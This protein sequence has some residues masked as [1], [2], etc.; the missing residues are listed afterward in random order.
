M[1]KFLIHRP[2]AVTMTFIAILVLGLIASLR[3]PV[4]LMPS[5]DI[6]RI[7]VQVSGNG[8]SAR[9]LENTVVRSLR[10]Q[11]LQVSHLSEL[12]SETRDGTALIYL[13]FDYG[14]DI[15]FAF[16]E[17]NEKIDRAMGS[18]P[19][20]LSRPKVIKAS[21]TDIPVFY[22]NIS[23][24][25]DSANFAETGKFNSISSQ[26]T[27]LSSFAANV[28]GKRIEQLPEVAMVDLSGRVFP[29]LLIIPD[30]QKMEALGI[31]LSTLE[32]AIRKND[33]RLGNLLIHNGQYQY[34][35]RFTSTLKT[36]R[37]IENI[38]LKV[39]GRLM[40]MKELVAVKDQ[41][42]KRKGLVTSGGTLAIT[43]AIIKQSDAR[44]F[45]LKKELYSLVGNFR[46][47]YPDLVF[48]INRDQTRLLDYSLSN[49]EQSLLYGAIL[50]FAIMFF[51]LKDYKSPFLVGITIPVS[52]VISLLF[53]YLIGLSI[54][55]ISLSGLIL[56]MGMMIDNSIIVIDNITQYRERGSRLD[57]SCVTATNEVIRPMLSS[58]LTTCAIFIPLIFLSGMGGA[59]FYDQAMAVTIGMFISLVVSITLLPVYYRLMYLKN[60]DMESGKLFKRQKWMD[61]GELYEKGFRYVMRHQPVIWGIVILLLI[62]GGIFF[63]DMHKSKLPPITRDEV[64]VHI[65]WNEPVNLEENNRRVQK[66]VHSLGK[67]IRQ[68]TCLVGEQQFLLDYSGSESASEAMIYIKAK[69]QAALLKIE[70]NTGSF[71]QKQ[72]PKAAHQFREAENVFTLLFSGE[73]PPLVIRLRAT[74]DF[75]PETN[76]FLQQTLEYL[77]DAFPGQ[78]IPAI[79]WKNQLV[80]KTDPVKLLTYD[81]SYD[82]V[83][84][85]LKSAFSSNRILLITQNRSYVP[86]VLGAEP[87]LINSI[88]AKTTV[89]NKDGDLIP[90]R[91]LLT[92]SNAWDLKTI[93]AGE[94]GVYYPVFF[95]IRPGEVAQVQ[96]KVQEVLRK[97]GHFEA[98][99]TGSIFSNRKMM[100]Q[101]AVILSISLLLLY[102]ILAAQFESL[103][104]P[105]IL[106]AEI[107]VDFAGVLLM[108]AIFKEGINL[109]SMIGIIVMGGIVINDSIL[110]IDTINQLRARGYSLLHAIAEGGKRRLKP[111]LMTSLTTILALIPFLFSKG[112]GADLQRPLALA[113]I[114]GLGLGTFVSLYFVPLLYYLMERRKEMPKI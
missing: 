45:D 79:P 13:D 34:N 3:I 87:T 68:N 95:N 110:K 113:V 59:L 80:L 46:E 71:L 74:G 112:L 88:L 69:S 100:R 75:G 42:Q 57:E 65:D 23:L 107:P 61:Y 11:L 29:E 31:S 27:A 62:T 4:S 32:E 102:F 35:I 108:L 48:H 12:N 39:E 109:M 55:I 5:I 30:K 19:R 97:D 111:I 36:K 99:F 25:T 63:Y 18:L 14:A 40:Q 56:G 82:V 77:R 105:F 20:D 70:D 89:P 37:D 33:I 41:V 81:V 52:L 76:R 93:L 98:D 72:Y 8:L 15:D 53:F 10:N 83:Y 66:M 78:N 96:N 28:I 67:D 50:A 92:Q 106:L 24:K 9:E 64:M 58:V 114:G 17:V 2:I 49:L 84:R 26:F 47:D 104:L 51:F 85:A 94:G 6:P 101:L 91:S 38:Y 21:A 22:L 103:K 7:T 43:M 54:N 86:V 90:L 16:I 60:P 1:V 73:E 44:M